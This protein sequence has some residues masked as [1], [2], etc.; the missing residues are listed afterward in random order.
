MPSVENT[1]PIG[2]L[3]T[4]GRRSNARP[5]SGWNT[6]EAIWYMSVISPICANERERSSF[7]IG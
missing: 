2:R 7:S 3:H 1:I 5:T 4:K 6:D